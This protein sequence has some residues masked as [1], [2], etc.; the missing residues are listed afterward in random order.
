MIGHS[1][2]MRSMVHTLCRSYDRQLA[3]STYSSGINKFVTQTPRSC[4]LSH[5]NI[6][7]SNGLSLRVVYSF[8]K[9]LYDYVRNTGLLCM[10][11]LLVPLQVYAA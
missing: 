11:L 5:F 3:I 9:L 4:T 7:N 8:C 1:V 6:R 10:H 2:F